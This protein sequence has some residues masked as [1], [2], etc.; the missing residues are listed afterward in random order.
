[1]GFSSKP[2]RVSILLAVSSGALLAG[3]VFKSPQVASKETPPKEQHID[4]ND[5]GGADGVGI[6]ESDMFRF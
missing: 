4:A 2:I 1:M 5:T 6:K 3:C